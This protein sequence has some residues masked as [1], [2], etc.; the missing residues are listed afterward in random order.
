MSNLVGEAQRMALRLISQEMK[1]GEN[2]DN[3]MRRVARKC[4]VSYSALWALR[5]RAPKRIFADIY[6]AIQ[7][8]HEATVARERQKLEH[9]VRVAEARGV[10]TDIARSIGGIRRV[11]QP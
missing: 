11:N 8:A 3:A 4:G 1:E 2:T 5:Y 9:E 10:N 6:F 7:T